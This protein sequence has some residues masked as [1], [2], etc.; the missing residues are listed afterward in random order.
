MGTSDSGLQGAV[1]PE[2][3]FL[4][5]ALLDEENLELQV[6]CTVLME[7]PKFLSNGKRLKV[8]GPPKCSIDIILY[9]PPELAEA[10]CTFLDECNEHLED[11]QKLYLQDP[12]GCTHNVPYCNPQRLPPLDPASIALTSELAQKRTIHVDLDDIAPRPEL[13]ELLNSQEDLPEAAQPPAI[14]SSLEKC[15]FPSLRTISAMLTC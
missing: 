9:G 14:R 11:G 7:P 1:S 10:L 15:V 12:L 8:A 2:F 13:L 4:T 6:S 3:H 5:S